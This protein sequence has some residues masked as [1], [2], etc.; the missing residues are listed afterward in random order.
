LVELAFVWVWGV[1]GSGA[2]APDAS[3]PSSE[4]VFERAIASASES[5]AQWREGQYV[6][7]LLS[8]VEKYEKNGD[9]KQQI[10]SVYDAVVLEGEP[11]L[12]LTE[13]NGK[14][15][16][17]DAQ[18]K[19]RERQEE[20]VAKVRSGEKPPRDETQVDFDHEL[21]DRYETQFEGVEDVEGRPAFVYDYAPRPG[22][23]PERRRMD[24]VFNHS[25]G[26]IWIDK[27]DYEVARLEFEMEHEV[28]FWWFMGSISEL[29]GYY[30]RRP[31]DGVWLPAEGAMYI[32]GRV[33]FRSIRQRHE[34]SWIDFE[35]GRPEAA[36][37]GRR[38]PLDS[39]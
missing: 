38:G 22:K 2:H 21:V 13:R 30:V 4:E 12:R 8:S 37:G 16:D 29:R 24:R 32:R 3:V 5:Q 35:R 25:R 34:A 14:P 1:L 23:L 7:R 20:F 11:Y 15:L 36:T 33:V 26:R 18:A 9:I 27:E 10:D 31:V 6:Y 39:F 19:E 28:R 17:E